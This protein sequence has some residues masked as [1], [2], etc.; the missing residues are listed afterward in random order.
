MWHPWQSRAPR[1]HV[2]RA[3]ARL[4]RLLVTGSSSS[5]T[6]GRGEQLRPRSW[7]AAPRTQPHCQA[8][9]ERLLA[10]CCAAVELCRELPCST[11]LARL[12]A[13][14]GDA[15]SNTHAV[16]HASKLQEKER[17]QLLGDKNSRQLLER[18]MDA[19]EIN[20]V[21]WVVVLA[22]SSFHG[23]E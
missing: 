6:L 17:A 9:R 4:A 22:V 21:G 18:S 23:G 15:P 11:L 20:A 14:S 7:G 10:P 13:Y 19:V 16:E 3:A 12:D 8:W 5:P 1:V 2:R